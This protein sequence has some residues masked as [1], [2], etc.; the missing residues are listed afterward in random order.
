MKIGIL[1][2]HNADN[3][4]AVLQCYALQEKLKE[5][6]PDDE[7]S[8]VNYKCPRIEKSYI[9][10]FKI[11]RPWTILHYFK[12]KKLH[13]K[14][15]DFRTKYLNIGSDD[16]S[17]Y[18]LIVYGSDQIW[19]S[20]LTER[21]LTYFGKN[22]N[23]HKI[24]YAASDGGEMT[25]DSDVCKLLNDFS[26]ISCR[27]KSITENLKKQNLLLQV[28]TVCDPVF[29][30]SKDKWLKIAEFPQEENYVLTYKV[31]ENINFDS[32]AEKLGKELNKK[33]IQ[34]V[35]IKSLRKLFYKGQHIVEG[36][37]PEQ[38][39]GYIAKA[40]YVL[41]TSFHATA[42]SIIFDKPFFVLNINKASERITDLLSEFKISDRYG[43]HVQ[44][45]KLTV[46]NLESY[47]QNSCEF[48]SK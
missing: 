33:V 45:S 8:L 39:L 7:V 15:Q 32:E 44:E 13:Q 29:L 37:S 26:K 1:T 14:F 18:D 27:E 4:G 19:N 36:I 3:Y 2:F 23:G 16:F 17:K 48:F 12:L 46:E 34:I 42:F 11:L 31:R 21:D 5:L 24:A 47:V 40:E 10:K 28:A 9:P 38:F 30:L 20:H 22:Y 41:T 6:Y 25:Y 35:Y 43:L